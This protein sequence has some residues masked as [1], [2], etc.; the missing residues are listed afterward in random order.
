MDLSTSMMG[1]QLAHPYVAGA[2]PLGRGI[3]SVRRLE[4][5][6]AAAIVL[7][8]M[9]EEQVTLASEGRIRHKDP[10]DPRASASLL[11]FPAARDYA[12]TPDEYAEHVAQAHKAVAVPVIA[13]LNGTTSESWLTFARLIEQAGADA[14]ELNMYEVVADPKI[15]GAAI[16][17][18]LVQLAAELTQFVRIPIAFK[19]SPFFASLGNVVHRLETAGAAAVVLFNRFYQ[20][21][22]DIEKMATIADA[23]LSW[24]DELLLRLRWLA[25]LHG[26]V[27]LSLVA[28]G[29]IAGPEDGIKAILA[30]ADAV[31]VVSAL[32]R[33]GP[34]YL[35]TLRSGLE[36][37]M[38]RKG[39]T[40]L[41]EVHGGV[42]LKDVTDPSGFER[43]LYLRT[44][45][46][47][48]PA[49]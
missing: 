26:R 21:D 11:H 36:A 46:A 12:F 33:H 7:P 19:L 4:D 31:Q 30:G 34:Q 9:F 49:S 44:L 35:T 10:N 13:S 2:S 24:S 22:I 15:S 42:S 43:A 18:Q 47:W 48:K 38:T 45:Q 23:R 32:L 41:A 25:I 28:S 8:S 37:W 27:R 39:F 17:H 14:L 6:G 1:L 16:E 29:G 40:S 3:D 5:A 20:P